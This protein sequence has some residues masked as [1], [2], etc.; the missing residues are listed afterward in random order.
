MSLQSSL[1]VDS[2]DVSLQ[3]S[4]G[5]DSGDVSLQ[6]SLGVVKTEADTRDDLLDPPIRNAATLQKCHLTHATSSI[7][8]SIETH[9]W[10]MVARDEGA[11]LGHIDASRR[12]LLHR[13]DLPFPLSTPQGIETNAYLL[14]SNTDSGE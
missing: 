4:L 10:A 14:D 6:S 9:A 2:G 3:S 1:G 7:Y 13:L 8:R 12:R 5:V 11:V